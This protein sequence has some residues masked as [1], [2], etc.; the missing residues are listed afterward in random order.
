MTKR[1]WNYRQNAAQTVQ[2]AHRAR[3]A[4]HK[5]SFCGLR[6]DG[7]TWPIERMA[8]GRVRVA[9]LFRYFI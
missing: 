4:E 9:L 6:R 1:E 8:P 3:S 5:T 2:L 7:G